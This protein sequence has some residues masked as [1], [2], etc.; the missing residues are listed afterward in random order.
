MLPSIEITNKADFY[1]TSIW[2]FL[3]KQQF[4]LILKIQSLIAHGKYNV[5]L[6]SQ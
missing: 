6:H 3:G 4:I 5:G 1:L 2:L